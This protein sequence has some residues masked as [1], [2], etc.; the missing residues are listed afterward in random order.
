[1]SIKYEN[2]NA[3]NVDKVKEIPV[4]YK[5]HMGVPV[6]FLNKYNP[7]Q[8]EI[9]GLSISSSGIEMG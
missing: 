2:Y 5:G 8:F 9:I 3:I 7:D 6:T 1:M 4:D